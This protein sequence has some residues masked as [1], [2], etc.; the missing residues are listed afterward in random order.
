M[1]EESETETHGLRHQY[2]IV[3]GIRMHYVEQGTG[4]LV[5]LLHGFP[6]FW[7]SWR[8]QIPALAAAGFRVVAP[9]Q[10]GYNLSEKPRGV[11]NF[12][13][14]H[15]TAGVG[16]VPCLQFLVLGRLGGIP[17]L[18]FEQQQRK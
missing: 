3:N 10:R 6:E 17:A 16:E 8:K 2:A 1:T 13:L 14:D 18:A 4:P 7:Y 15:L 11:A 9:D 12:D 5:V